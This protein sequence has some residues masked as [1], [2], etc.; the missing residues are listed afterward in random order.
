METGGMFPNCGQH[1]VPMDGV[2]GIPEVVSV[3]PYHGKITQK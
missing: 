3:L 1:L 2:E